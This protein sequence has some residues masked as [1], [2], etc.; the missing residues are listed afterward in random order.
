MAENYLFRS[1][2]VV[3]AKYD[4]EKQQLTVEF[5][6]NRKYRYKKVP[7]KVWKDFKK[8][9]SAGSF[10]ADRLSKYNYTEL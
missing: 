9:A 6:R 5:V 1:T 4:K 10:V 2:N 8:A 7:E 3:S